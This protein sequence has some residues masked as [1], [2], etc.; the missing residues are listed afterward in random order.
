MDRDGWIGMDGFF[1]VVVVVIFSLVFSPYRFLET[2]EN[3][4]KL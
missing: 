2:L 4:G 3:F 1:V